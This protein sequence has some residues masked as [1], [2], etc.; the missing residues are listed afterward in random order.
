[1]LKIGKEIGTTLF[2]DFLVLGL[3]K[4]W[5]N[6]F[7]ELPKFGATLDKDGKLHLVSTKPILRSKKNESYTKS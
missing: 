1:M 2:G 6:A 4:Q 5:L 7:G 3:S